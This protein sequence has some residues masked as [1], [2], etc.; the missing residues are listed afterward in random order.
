MSKIRIQRLPLLTR[1]NSSVSSCETNIKLISLQAIKI[2]CCI[3]ETFHCLVS[4]VKF[5]YSKIESGCTSLAPHI[6]LFVHI[7]LQLLE[8]FYTIF[9]FVYSALSVLDEGILS[10]INSSQIPGLQ[11]CI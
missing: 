10:K 2:H 8:F 6:H 7:A 4:V 1:Y 5:N 9:A 3:D 11:F